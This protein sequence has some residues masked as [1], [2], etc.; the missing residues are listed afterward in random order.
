MPQSTCK[1]LIDR[2]SRLEG[3]LASIKRELQEMNPDCVQASETLRA[4]SRS[5]ASLKQAFVACFFEQKFLR[6]K[7]AATKEGS[8]EYAALLDLIRS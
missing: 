1:P 7:Q 2:I 3:Q 4:A 6:E 8:E 5:F